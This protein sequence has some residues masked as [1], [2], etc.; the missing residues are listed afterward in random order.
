[1]V[2]LAELLLS[3]SAHLLDH[4]D[5][6]VGNSA[7]HWAAAKDHLQLVTFLLQR[8]A[9]I[10]LANSSGGTALHSAAANGSAS[11]VEELLRHGCPEGVRDAE[12]RSAEAWAEVRGHGEVLAAMR[13]FSSSIRHVNAV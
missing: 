5:R 8:G 9:D 4:Q 11:C 1:M 2:G 10:A 12:G 6:A 13:R 7:L 3:D